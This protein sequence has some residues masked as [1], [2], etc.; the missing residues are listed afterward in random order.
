MI[1]HKKRKELAEIR[2]L[3]SA[4]PAITF[5]L[6]TR[7]SLR[8]S[9]SMI[10]NNEPLTEKWYYKYLSILRVTLHKFVWQDYQCNAPCVTCCYRL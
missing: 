4:E 1:A 7:L 3:F 8:L 2:C 9:G 6:S 5:T 10:Y